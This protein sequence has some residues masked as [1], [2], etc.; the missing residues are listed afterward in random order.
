MPKSGRGYVAGVGL[1]NM[2]SG[3]TYV[4]G[5]KNNDAQYWTTA[6]QSG[7]AW[8]IDG[9]LPGTYTLN[10][11]KGVSLGDNMSILSNYFNWCPRLLHAN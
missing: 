2:K 9:V 8:R 6:A 11:F 5:L 4:V 3:Y 7:G 10:V 1:K